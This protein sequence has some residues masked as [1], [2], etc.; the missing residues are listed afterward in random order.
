MLRDI[1]GDKMRVVC[2]PNALKGC[3]S[4]LDAAAALARGACRADPSV[5][6]ELLPIADGGDGT[7]EVLGRDLGG[8]LIVRTVAGPLG[9]PVESSYLRLPEG[10]AVIELARASGLRL[11]RRDRL[12]AAAAHTFGVGELV[13]DAIK[14]GASEIILALGGSASTDCA[15]GLLSALGARFLDAAGQPI[16]LGCAALSKLASIDI[17]AIPPSVRAAK[18]TVLCDVENPLC[19]PNGTV[20]VFAPQKGAQD[21]AILAKLSAAVQNFADVVKRQFDISLHA[22]ERCGVAGGTSAGLFA[23]LGAELESGFDYVARLLE[24]ERRIACADLVLTSE[25]R[26]DSQTLNG[27]GPHG[28]AL[29]A[30]RHDVAVVGIFGQ[31]DFDQRELFK[32]FTSVQSLASGPTT[33]EQLIDTTTQRLEFAAESSVRLVRAAS[34]S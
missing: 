17:S 34:K 31:F 16:E 29:I 33:L 6:A 23:L 12:N 28:V 9:D 1:A 32:D 2:A 10:R 20:A 5:S 30:A 14:N 13:L 8:E 19:G 24:I 27:K 26:L 21:Q 4:A 3:L 15:T 18:F 25:G 11:L 22:R 7:L